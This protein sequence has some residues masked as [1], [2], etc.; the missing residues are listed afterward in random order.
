MSS[1]AFMQLQIFSPKY[2]APAELRVFYFRLAIYNTLMFVTKNLWFNPQNSNRP[3][4]PIAN[5]EVLLF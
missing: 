3:F 2:T 1:V 5:A 4:E